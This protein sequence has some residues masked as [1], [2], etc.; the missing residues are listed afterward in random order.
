MSKTINIKSLLIGFLLA[1]S[2]MLFMG[3]TSNNQIGK[4]Q[5]STCYRDAG[6]WVFETIINTE[7]GEIISRERKGGFKLYKN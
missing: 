2:V 3:A 1:T 4:Y 7:T 5:V 6:N